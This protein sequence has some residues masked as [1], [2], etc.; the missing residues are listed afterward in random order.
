MADNDRQEKSASIEELQGLISS[1][2]ADDDNEKDFTDSY[3]QVYEAPDIVDTEAMK[4]GK[5]T[6]PDGALDEKP[7]EKKESSPPGAEEGAKKQGIPPEYVSKEEYNKLLAN[8]RSLE[9]RYGNIN[10]K[11]NNVLDTVKA[12]TSGGTSPTSSEIKSA[13]MDQAKMDELRGEYPEWA[14]FIDAQ[15]HNIDQK[16]NNKFDE[17]INSGVDQVKESVMRSYLDTRHKNWKNTINT[18]GF[19][20]WYNQQDEETRRLADSERAVDAIALLD[21][22]EESAR[23]P[24][25]KPDIQ[26]TRKPAPER[27]TPDEGKAKTQLKQAGL[28]QAGRGRNV[29]PHVSSEED[30]FES[31]Y[32]GGR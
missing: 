5:P 17:K 28:R 8:I 12:Q 20:G 11:V 21:M 23:N 4:P 9:G 3:D 2:G 22:F 29:A 1:A 31:A 10:S 32:K 30:E 27:E 18:D 26:D 14:Q 15:L 13:M 7:E 25:A 24:A 19:M 16:L 6:K